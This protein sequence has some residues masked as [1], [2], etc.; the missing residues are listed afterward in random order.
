MYRRPP[1][2]AHSCTEYR[3]YVCFV[4]PNRG[5]VTCE[6]LISI[7]YVTNSEYSIVN[8]YK[9]IIMH[10]SYSVKSFSRNPFVS[11]SLKLFI[12][13]V[14]CE[15]YQKCA[16]AVTNYYFVLLV[17]FIIL[18]IRYG[19]CLHKL[20]FSINTPDCKASLIFSRN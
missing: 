9:P 8:Y 15:L 16:F 7:S 19:N 1:Q 11:I 4:I 6:R 17:L 20:N 12:A 3:L 18:S 2:I 5:T 10:Q 14:F 13:T